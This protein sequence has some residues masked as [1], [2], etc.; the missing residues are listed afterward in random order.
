ML[1]LGNGAVLLTFRHRLKCSIAH[2]ERLAI[3]ALVQFSRQGRQA[4]DF[5]LPMPQ[6]ASYLVDVINWEKGRW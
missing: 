3:V 2:E 6:R 5:V 1:K 4:M